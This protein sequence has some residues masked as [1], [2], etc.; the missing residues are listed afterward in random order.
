MNDEHQIT[1]FERQ[2]LD[3]LG[4]NFDDLLARTPER[5]RRSADRRVAMGGVAVAACLAIVLAWAIWPGDSR[6]GV[7]TAIGSIADVAAAQ[8]A[9]RPN[10]FVESESVVTTLAQKAAQE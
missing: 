10:Q 3:R 4:R 7:D 9:P 2:A 8:E 5:R 1:P 6:F